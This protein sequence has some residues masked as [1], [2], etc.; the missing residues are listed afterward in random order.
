MTVGMT[1][2]MTT[3]RLAAGTSS[4]VGTTTITIPTELC[5]PIAKS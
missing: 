2:G 5:E 1:V 3:V 4:A